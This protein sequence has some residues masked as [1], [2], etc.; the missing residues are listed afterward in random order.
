MRKYLDITKP[1]YSKQILP[2]PW[3]FV[4]SRFHCILYTDNKAWIDWHVIVNLL[5]QKMSIPLPQK[6]FWLFQLSPTLSFRN[7]GFWDSPHPS[8]FPMT[9][10]MVGMDIFWNYTISNLLSAFCFYF[11]VAF[12]FWIWNSCCLVPQREDSRTQMYLFSGE[13][14]QDSF[15][16]NI[17]FEQFCDSVIKNCIN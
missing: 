5:F 13:K 14:G 8:E 10:H 9:C 4:I 7:F 12:R 16:F 1:H 6:E 17:K 3:S 2:V 15:L 11:S